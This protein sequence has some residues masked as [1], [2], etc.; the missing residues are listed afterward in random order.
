MMRRRTLG[1]GRSLAALAGLVLIAACVL[2]W[3]R[4]GGEE[5]IPAVGGNG[6]EG[7]GIIVFLVGVATLFL[8]ALP[9]AAGD[10]P[11]GLDRALSYWALAIVGWLGF[12]VRF[13][14]LLMSG[15]LSFREP[16]QV[17]TNGP[18]LWLAAIGLVT[19][20]RAAYEVSREPAYR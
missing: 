10:R 18:G 19:L 1:R 11:V 3:W 5:G 15:A 12:L 20:S 7:S 6:F 9:F 14:D 8:V 13:I 4:L 16:A 17:F 2:S